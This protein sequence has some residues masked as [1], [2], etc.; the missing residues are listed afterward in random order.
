MPV[1]MDI[2]VDLTLNAEDIEQRGILRLPR[3]KLIASRVGILLSIYFLEGWRKEKRQALMLCL[4]EYFDRFER[5]I[6][7]Y[8]VDD[9]SSMRR[10][11]GSGIP[12]AYMSFDKLEEDE[13]FYVNVQGQEN[14]K[15]SDDP[16][17]WKFMAFGQEKNNFRNRLSGLKAHIPPSFVFANLDELTDLVRKWSERLGAIHGSCGLGT[18]SVPGR[19][20][21][22]GAY[23]YPWLMQYPAL[24]YDAMGDYF[25][26]SE[27]NEGYIWPRS[28]NWLTLLGNNNVEALGGVKSIRDKLTPEMALLPFDGGILVRASEMPA[29]GNPDMSGIPEGYFTIARIIKPIR[30]EGYK[31]NVLKAPFRN[32]N[33]AVT[34]SWIRR[35]D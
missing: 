31:Y 3:T 10:Y 24:E 11:K 35:F 32:K 30:F 8:Q 34:L 29:L 13:L 7:Y 18:L 12:E 23:Y 21:M 15:E 27:E 1:A 9:E 6:K 5:D 16:S 4:Q 2:P 14:E 25:V 26:E 28:S 22:G 20:T 19:E 33:A 17:L